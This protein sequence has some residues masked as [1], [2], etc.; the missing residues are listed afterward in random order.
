MNTNAPIQNEL[1]YETA[2]GEDAVVVF[3]NTGIYRT[4]TKGT[5]EHLYEG[6]Y[7]DDAAASLE[8]SEEDFGAL[9][10]SDPVNVDE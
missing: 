3:Q 1:R 5:V 9:L 7:R 6:P 10:M 4:Y 2:D 8:M